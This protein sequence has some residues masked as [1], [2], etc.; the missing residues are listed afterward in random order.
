MPV[1][2]DANAQ[3]AA[4][5]PAAA[6]A[7]LRQALEQCTQGVLQDRLNQSQVALP[8]LS[9]SL[10][11]FLDDITA[12]TNGALEPQGIAITRLGLDVTVPQ[13][14]VQPAA[15]QVMSGSEI[16]TNVAGNF[17]ENVIAQN[18]PR[19]RLRAN[20]R[21]FNVDVGPG[22]SQS[23]GEQIGDEI[24]SRILHYVILGGVVLFVGGVCVI[25]MAVK[26][27]L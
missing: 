16:A 7:P 9:Q 10:A 2:V 1:T 6:Q 24:G 26:L 13:T 12:R 19:P 3:Y 18:M 27:L 14:A 22:A 8:T 5:D 21:G 20:V 17:A 23:V 11:Y 4:H 15:G 25:A